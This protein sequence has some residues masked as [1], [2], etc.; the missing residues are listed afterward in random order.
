MFEDIDKKLS[1]MVSI[2][3]VS[4][5]GNEENYHIEEYRNYLKEAF[6]HLLEGADEIIEVGAARRGCVHRVRDKD[7]KRWNCVSVTAQKEAMVR[8]ARAFAGFVKL[9]QERT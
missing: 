6:P 2:P 7:G 3:T 1:R 9:Y 4:G 8:K 5:K